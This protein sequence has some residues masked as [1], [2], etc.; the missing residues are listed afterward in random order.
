MRAIRGGPTVRAARGGL[1]GRR[2]QAMVIGLVILVSTAA[3]TLALGLLVDS[4][5][6]FDHAFAA[7]RGSH[8]TAAVNTAQVS[9]GQLA[10]TSRLPGVTAA[11]GP[12]AETTV[13]VL[14]QVPG[15]PGQPTGVAQF[16]LNVAGRASPGGPVDDLTLTSG[17]WARQPG[18]VVLE[19][20]RFGPALTLGTKVTAT[21]LPGSPH[22][23]VVGF[24]TSVTTTAQAWVLPA[25][26]AALRAPGAPD[27]A[28]MLYRFS[29]AGTNAQVNA[30]IAAIRAALPPG[31]LLSAQSYLTVKLQATGS[32]APWVPFIVAFGLI[33]LVMSVLI[34]ANVVSG[35]VAAGTRRIGVLKSIGFSPG[36]V[37][38]V[39]LIQVAV[40]ALAG[41]V[42]GVLV[43]N[44]LSVPLLGQTAQVYGVGALAVPVWVDL[45]VPLAMLGLAGAA[46]L[47]PSLRAARLSAVQAIATGR[48]PR[49]S[50]GY[51]AH[52]LLGRARRLPRPV[53]IGLAGPFARPAR[54]LVTLAA[55]VF[56][57]VAVTFATG[58]GTSLDRVEADLSHAASQ[59]V[60]VYLPGP[61]PNGS[62]ASPGAGPGRAGR[63]RTRGAGRAAGSAR[64]AALRSRSRRPDQRARPGRPPVAGRLRRRRQLDRVR[65][66][67]RA[68]V[69][70][71]RSR[72]AGRREYGLPH[73]DRYGRRGQLHAHL[74]RQARHGADRRRDFAPK[75][76]A[77]RSSPACRP[78][79]AWI[80]A[81]PWASTTWRCGR[82]P[83]P[84]PTRTRSAGRSAWTIRSTP[85]RTACPSCWPS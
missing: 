53:T 4:N 44:L 66:G 49:A 74:R 46:A 83:T 22:L 58:L 29:S 54:T 82:G 57:V 9:S 15:G 85:N 14:L 20:D 7:Q 63:T 2:V 55:I 10:A 13:N 5:A 47:A 34:V 43:G 8:V 25:E 80:P 30:D 45:A 50:G 78:W 48:A 19:R 1:A 72:D 38:A 65:A 42:A 33:G 81:W 73:R 77:R 24:A 26:L 62:A 70:R 21:G 12:F 17:R 69:R 37:V 28:Q 67:H 71:D 52:R 51:A 79:P 32:I 11:A 75:A 41:C 84:R 18:E 36:Q 59:P 27:V 56:G 16:Q 68:L 31:S 60:Q 3:S 61:G 64:Y 40:P 76:A 23:T 39:Y 35:A 6:P